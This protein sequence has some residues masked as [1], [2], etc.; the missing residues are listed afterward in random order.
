MSKCVTLE[1]ICIEL[2]DGL[3]K[4]PQF[5][6]DGEYIFVNAN[7][8]DNGYIIY[9]NDGKR[10]DKSEYDKYKIELDENTVLYSIDGTI[11]KIAKYRNEKVILG[12]GACYLR[13]KPEVN[14]DYIY[15]LLQ[16]PHFSAYINTMSTGSTIHHIS[17]ATMRN[18]EFQLPKKEDQDVI[19]FLLS[20][21]D[22]KVNINNN[23]ISVLESMAKTLYDYWFVQFDFPDANGQPYKTSGGKMVW[24]EELGREIPE[25]WE[26]KTIREICETRLGG[27]PDTNNADYWGGE[28]PWLNSGEVAVSPILESEKAITELGRDNSATSIAAP[29]DVLMSITRYIRPSILGITACYNQSVVAIIQNSSYKTSFIYPFL[30]SQVDRY[31]G[32][33]IGAQQP[34]INKKI[35]D[36]T[37]VINPTKEIL[38][39]YYLKIDKTYQQIINIAKETKTLISLRD[40][41]LPLLMNGQVTFK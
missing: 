27:T 37:P 36:S 40:F 32:L 11:G 34:H 14:A 25:G 13:I 17:L 16:S 33:R 7:N 3:H 20:S 12:K 22:N 30:L 1:E 26:I 2:S 5:N 35:V 19:A 24:N 15:Y 6:P 8:L 10:A 23:T 39:A 31:M 21:I 9:P 4:A 38:E 41:L 28:I 29:G 18:Y